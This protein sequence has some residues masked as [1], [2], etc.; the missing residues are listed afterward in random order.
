[1]FKKVIKKLSS[2]FVVMLPLGI[3]T[4]FASLFIAQSGVSHYLMAQSTPTV[5]SPIGPGIT[6]INPTILNSEVMG[7]NLAAF[8]SGSKMV[9]KISNNSGFSRSIEATRCITISAVYF[10]CDTATGENGIRP[11]DY[12][13]GTYNVSATWAGEYVS[14]IA[15]IK[16]SNGKITS[17]TNHQV[18]STSSFDFT[19]TISD[20][21][22]STPLINF[23]LET[24]A[25][26]EVTTW[27]SA[28]SGTNSHITKD[29]SL[30]P[31]GDYRIRVKST[32]LGVVYYTLPV[33]FT[34][35]GGMPAVVLDPV[36]TISNP[37]ESIIYQKEALKVKIED[38][39]Y[40]SGYGPNNCKFEIR[41]KADNSL[42]DEIT[43][44]SYTDMS[45]EGYFSCQT[46][47]S[48]G[49]NPIDYPQNNYTIT[50]KFTPDGI[51]YHESDPF[52]I[53]TTGGA[54][55]G[56]NEG[57][58]ISSGSAFFRAQVSVNDIDE[59]SFILETSAGSVI[60]SFDAFLNSTLTW[61]G[62]LISSN[63]PDGDYRVKMIFNY[64]A[65]NYE[66]NYEYF[67]IQN[68]TLNIT[69][70]APTNTNFSSDDT[71]NFIAGIDRP[72][73]EVTDFKFIIND[74]TT[75]ILTSPSLSAYI[76]STDFS[77][78][79]YVQSLS[80]FDGDYFA[81]VQAEV[82]GKIYESSPFSFTVTPVVVPPVITPVSSVLNPTAGE[83]VSNQVNF[84]ASTNLNANSISN[85]TFIVK[86]VDTGS[87]NSFSGSA[88]SYVA[89]IQSWETSFNSTS[90]SNG[91]Y[92]VKISLDY[93][94]NNYSSDEVSFK[95]NNSTVI[96][97]DPV[98]SLT[99]PASGLEITTGDNLTVFGKVNKT[100]TDVES[101]NFNIIK[102]GLVFRSFGG[103]LQQSA[104]GESLWSKV[105]DTT[106]YGGDYKLQAEVGFNG[107]FYIS[108]LADMLINSSSNDPVDGEPVEELPADVPPLDITFSNLSAVVNNG[109]L[110]IKINS[111]VG[112]ELK[113]YFNFSIINDNFGKLVEKPNA[114]LN[115]TI[116][117]NSYEWVKNIDITGSNYVTGKY[118]T[119][120]EFT[121]NNKI[122]KSNTISFYIDKRIAPDDT[123]KPEPVPV[124]D[125]T[126][127]PEPVP[128]PDDTTKP[129]P[130]G[131]DPTGEYK[132]WP[133]DPTVDDRP[134]I[135][136][137]PVPAPETVVNITGKIDIIT[138]NLS[139]EKMGNFMVRA[140]STD[141]FIRM[142][143]VLIG[144][145]KKYEFVAN[146]DGLTDNKWMSNVTVIEK[147]IESGSYEIF[148]EGVLI[149][150][151]IIESPSF[152]VT[153][154]AKGSSTLSVVI[155]KE[156]LDRGYNN[157]D[158]CMDYLALDPLCK[159]QGMGA[160]DI[161]KCKK[162]LFVESLP[163]ICQNMKIASERECISKLV[164][165]LG[166]SMKCIDA[167]LFDK[168][169]CDT[170]ISSTANLVN[171]DTNRVVIEDKTNNNFAEIDENCMFY[172]IR[173][174]VECNEFLKVKNMS[175]EC[176]SKNIFKADKCREY[177]ESKYITQEC[178]DEG[179]ADKDECKEYMFKKYSPEIKCEGLN[180]WQCRN[181]IKE[182]YIENIV[183]KEKITENI[184]DKD[185][186]K[187]NEIK[188]VDKLKNQL[189]LEDGQKIIPLIN[190]NLSIK[191]VNAKEETFLTKENNL[192][193]AYPVVIVVD[194]DE[195]GLSDDMEREIGTDP[196]NKDTDGDGYTDGDEIKKGYSPIIS[197]YNTD[198]D[199][200]KSLENILKKA[201]PMTNAILANKT[202]EHPK[203][204]GNKT[205][206]LL[207]EK[208]E[209]IGKDG[210][211][212][213]GYSVTG[214]GIA[215]EYVTLYIY[216]DMPVVVT[217]KVDEYGNWNYE[218][219]ES[220]TDGEHE[221]YVVVN[222]NT[223][224]VVTKSNPLKFF[225]NEARAESVDDVVREFYSN[226]ENR[227]EESKMLF[228]Y[229]FFVGGIAIVGVVA[230][231]MFIAQ[232]KRENIE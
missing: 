157:M 130:D 128:A 58:T 96:V 111:S 173:N 204:S 103:V 125:D 45:H 3:I 175:F 11:S 64:S 84:S 7:T 33:Y 199:E 28:T 101:F 12:P 59:P 35:T 187:L 41:Y 53:T 161:D 92:T 39:P 165:E 9:F 134:Y 195:D 22:Y 21:F 133:T 207:V 219:K 71:A 126:T 148:A 23:V 189:G 185:V 18:V 106:G 4:V 117:A 55:T 123:T 6:I 221:V 25:G 90:Y 209:N 162:F 174:V 127:K 136:P 115:K 120:V 180:S 83:V 163:P 191:I 184:K 132:L 32:Y 112:E 151:K 190:N 76:T 73:G 113:G 145:N 8:P 216:S 179:V 36:L 124:P 203:T 212:S 149:N 94:G 49:F 105:I 194:S 192:I 193:Q 160:E 48:D 5:G 13:P 102:N 20:L 82:G 168:N 158:D 100:I 155:A 74:G 42:V 186:N 81:I 139:D 171:N 232:K 220:L 121:Y 50:A 34:L 218:F 188:N 62:E 170:F 206:D 131:T 181:I 29:L 143:F 104:G 77:Q 46:T 110:D 57:A 87:L 86:S 52:D 140:N 118:S 38:I 156:C 40:S 129:E 30:Y 56:D 196:N 224:R 70:I 183:A 210:D 43:A 153:I 116:L 60:G 10:Y 169:S 108:N 228:Y 137:T 44:S 227:T 119:F 99:A 16:I 225:I 54:M 215:G 202:I 142:V 98:V 198:G 138:D 172:G 201:S 226:D 47:S 197:A 205:D 31:N 200:V 166:F 176:F 109:Q 178:R 150:R 78:W 211:E 75:D 208:F 1:M 152:P 15:S 88:T 51:N 230:F 2:F 65:K 72:S 114:Y 27:G 167:G 97:V 147:G 91:D 231:M 24:P 19:A 68:D 69:M 146:K 95:I 154:A 213:E 214:K 107:K 141:A 144:N 159:R 222:D 229:F 164:N 177:L 93:D 63:Y 17:P 14:D 61:R 37:Y 182:S 217:T 67:T 79:S 135:D 122:Y 85:V 80:S 89:G 26:V 223:G 66:T